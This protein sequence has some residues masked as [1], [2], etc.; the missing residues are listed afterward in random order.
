[1]RFHEQQ[2][3]MRILIKISCRCKQL[4]VIW[5]LVAACFVIGQANYN[6]WLEWQ[7]HF[8]LHVKLS[9]NTL[10]ER[11]ESKKK[12]VYKKFIRQLMYSNQHWFLF[13]NQ[14][15][16]IMMFPLLYTMSENG[17]FQFFVRCRESLE[18]EFCMCLH[19][20]MQHTRTSKRGR[21]GDREREIQREE[22]REARKK[23]ST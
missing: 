2:S 3:P 12:A 19:W 8:I 17:A 9:Q 10:L 7:A 23:H 11:H 20:I 1:M 14:N 13:P 5:I 16:S 6:A 18:W 15:S 21:E 4:K 22:A